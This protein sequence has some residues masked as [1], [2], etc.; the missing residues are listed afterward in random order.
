MNVALTIAGSD[1]GGGAGIQADLKTFENLGVFGTSAITALTAQNTL[2]VLDIMPSTPEFLTAQ[3]KAVLDDFEVKAIKTGMLFDETIIFSVSE[4]LKNS[5]IPLVIDPVIIAKGGANL[6]KDSAK[7][8]LLKHLLP[9]STLITPNIPEATALSGVEIVDEKSCKKAANILLKRGAKNVII[10]G[11]H[12]HQKDAVD[13]LFL[14]N[15]KELTLGSPRIDTTNTHGTGCS[16]S[17]AITAFIAKGLS[18]EN[19]LKEA[20]KF[21]YLAIKFNPNL[22]HGNGPVL[23]SAYNKFKDKEIW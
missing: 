15:G 3:I 4:I 23:H 12:S 21:I 2:G 11:G 6:L 1:S 7:N 20:K 22:G 16:F 10:K 19:A 8:A 18:L 14:E 9:L 5:Q 17:A 13:Y